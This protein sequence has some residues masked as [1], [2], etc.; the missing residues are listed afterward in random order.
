LTTIII[1]ITIII[2]AAALQNREVM[3]K[4]IFNPYMVHTR[5]EWYRFISS[6]FIHADIVHLAVNMIVLYSFGNLLEAYYGEVFGSNAKIFFLLL[7]VSSLVFSIFPTYNN[8]KSNMYYNGLGA[9]GAVSAVMFAVILLDP[10]RNIYLFGAFGLPGIIYGAAYLYF[11]FYQ[12]KR[13]GDNINHSAHAWGAIYGFTFALFFRP[14]LIID[15][16]N[17]LIHFRH[18][19]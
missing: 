17:N 4:L 14:S 6:G 13:G 16:F 15:F 10:I 18:G 11:C 7:Y 12:G 9:S 2:S 3:S 19:I 8:H 1:I 5:N